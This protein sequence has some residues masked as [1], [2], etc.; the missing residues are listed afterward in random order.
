MRVQA[1]ITAAGERPLGARDPR[2]LA[3]HVVALPAVPPPGRGRRGRRRAAG[4]PPDARARDEKVAAL[5]PIPLLCGSRREGG[6]SDGWLSQLPVMSDHAATGGAKLAAVAALVVAGLGAAGVGTHVVPTGRA[7]GHSS[8]RPT[9][10]AAA[11]AASQ[12][13]AGRRAVLGGHERPRGLL[14]ERR[15]APA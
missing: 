13:Q 6:S 12:G 7:D 4:P 3:R 14:L 8:A 11:P 10:T 9:R 2:R 1:I 15:R 5:F